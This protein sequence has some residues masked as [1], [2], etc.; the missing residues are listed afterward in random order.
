MKNKITTI[1]LLIAVLLLAS[2]SVSAEGISSLSVSLLEYSPQPVQPGQ[3]MDVYIQVANKGDITEDSSVWIVEEYPLIVE[4]SQDVERAKNLGPVSTTQTLQFR[5]KI[6]ESAK[7]SIVPLR[8]RFK[9]NKQDS[10][11]VEEIF[12][13]NNSC[14]GEGS[15]FGNMCRLSENIDG[16]ILLIGG[17]FS[18][19]I[20]QST[21]IHHVEDRVG[22]SYRYLKR[23]YNTEDNREYV[24]QLVRFFSEEEHESVTGRKDSR[25]RFPI[26]PDYSRLG[27][28]LIRNGFL[29]VAPFGYAKTRMVN[30]KIFCD[31]LE[32]KLSQ[33]PDYCVKIRGSFS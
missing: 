14:F 9:S 10:G 12:D 17:A 15:V 13:I 16:Y 2:V 18:D 5:I 22:V 30:I 28:D 4:D 26:L 29:K 1:I 24:E 25:Y 3:V 8:V 23:F 7:D 27:E 32:E 19:D 20:F 33:Y 11:Y 31:F 6:D 21:Y